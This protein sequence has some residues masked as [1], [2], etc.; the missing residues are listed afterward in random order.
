MK[1]AAREPGDGKRRA[2]HTTPA[3]VS[4]AGAARTR[5]LN[6]H[7]VMRLQAGAGNAAVSR[8]IAPVA[9]AQRL[10]EGGACPPAPAAPV[11]ADPHADP[12][13][14][15]VEGKIG[16]SATDLKQHPAGKAEAK[17]AG[18]AAEPP[19]NDKAGKAKAAQADEMATAKPKGFD[20]AGFIAAV[21]QAIA[22]AAPK[23]LDE[24]AKFGTSGKADGVKG[25][26]L[27][28][29]TQGKEASAKDIA[30]KTAKP[31]DPSVAKDKPVTPLA[32]PT[33]PQPPAVDAAK[34]MPGKAPPEQTDM[35]GGP[36][37]VNSEMAKA[38]VT[39]QHL[40]ASN[41][42]QMQQAGAAKK[43]AEAH[44]ATAP[45]QIR[46]READ[47]LQQAQAG[48]GAE[49][50]GALVAMAGAKGAANAHAGGQ[51]N[52]AKAKEE[53]ERSRISGEIN[54]IFDKTKG[55]V[56][57]IL[58]GLDAKV[59]QEFD[60]GEGDARR[61][62]TAWHKAEMERYK[63][64][65]YSGLSG[66]AQ[67]AADLFSGVP[68][69]ANDIFDQA[70]AR[71]EKQMTAVISGIADTIGRELDAAKKKIAD[72]RQAI[73]DFVAK[74]PK[75]LQKLAGEA[76]TAMNG[77]F[78]QL[79]SD[80]DAKQQSLVDDLAQ[81]YVEARNA[82]DEEIKAEQAKNEGLVDMA[83]NAVGES[84]KSILQLKDLFMGLLAKAASAFH[85]IL[86]A[87]VRFITNFM[88]AVKQGFMNF[89]GNIVEH[90]KKGLQGWLFGQLSNA[91]IELPDKLDLMGILKMIA[92]LLGLTW[93]NIKERIAEKD[94]FVGK[95]IN[96]VESKIQIFVTLATKGIAG[97]WDMMKEKVGN[98]KQMVFDQIKS[99]IIEK[100]VKAGITW[101]LGMLNPAGALIK[102]VQALISVVQWIMERGAEMGEFIG[103]IID[104][105][106]DIAKGG[107]GGVP[108]KI[109]AAL[110]KAVPLVISF[111][112]G[113]LGLGGISEKVKSVI[114]KAQKLVGKGVDWVV[115]KALKLAR[116]LVKLLKKGVAYVKG[117]YE[118]AK[119]FVK[120]KYEAGKAWAKRQ[121][122]GVKGKVGA[123]FGDKKGKP[124]GDP[125]KNDEDLGPA[126][127]DATAIL[128][129]KDATHE[130][131]LSKLPSLVR[132]NGLR[133]AR[134]DP[135]GGQNS[136]KIHVQK[137]D[138][139]TAAQTLPVDPKSPHA[140]APGIGSI[141]VHGQQGV[142]HTKGP[143]IWH[144]ESEHIVPFRI[145]AMIWE[146]LDLP[147][148]RR[149]S[150]EDNQQTTIMLYKG[151][152]NRK[153]RRSQA[154]LFKSHADWPL[155]RLLKKILNKAK[156]DPP[157]SGAT[158]SRKKLVVGLPADVA[159]LTG[160]QVV[161]RT[162][163][164][165]TLDKVRSHA[166]A[167]T[168]KAI[169]EDYAAV[170][171][172][173][174]ENHGQRRGVPPGE[175]L[176]LPGD[177]DKAARAQVENVKD[178][179]AKAAQEALDDRR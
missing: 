154:G 173:I 33:K 139:D 9:G 85:M 19:S 28:K 17:K 2:G 72:G 64:R 41:E 138:A 36:C 30:D 74:E 66:A 46:Q 137:K 13:F 124:G 175:L 104:A 150:R 24:A 60:K 1:A 111:L 127:A 177:V 43:E 114:E 169:A 118:G 144:L 167:R 31:P 57:A 67:W 20:K 77:K 106:I 132:R 48:A 145:G 96:L 153:T 75:E 143:V 94:P 52:T 4:G 121:Y 21:K 174:P 63:D 115:G 15:A 136:F 163:I 134:L 107:G 83:K 125:K 97:I 116:P 102:I 90:L 8:L 12:K 58:T 120:A 10:A 99:F 29:V 50:K 179:A 149:K 109:E 65:R 38:E 129:S 25:E 93:A 69:E 147:K 81:K 47:V 101:V 176:P 142:R 161:D 22:K 78:D 61:D 98:L 80:V 112:A 40:A 23:N 79:E 164:S 146:E 100:I 117:K 148:I 141:E 76:A 7:T 113:L 151:A 88:N 131:I 56:E 126:I 156:D 37:A 71:Y 91:G 5:A 135:A 92:S 110:G 162:R 86:D 89:A 49:A 39:D 168:N 32:E 172:K 59:T 133:S 159:N 158:S 68:K 178:M 128:Q 11:P 87:P 103:T 140:H 166:V 170:S 84:V 3:R 165:T 155:I 122:E 34:A 18:A 53:V 108:A 105:V 51:R 55:E 14:A 160:R 42:P 157:D 171:E 123:M 27:G 70:K 119:K 26:V 62:F 95:A 44:A 54:R 35:R 73:K 6:P 45:A 82:V 16:N 130:S 152:A